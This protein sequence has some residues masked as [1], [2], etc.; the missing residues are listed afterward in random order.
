MKASVFTSDLFMINV[1]FLMLSVFF[2]F[3]ALSRK[4]IGI[5]SMLGVYIVL[6]VGMVIAFLTMAVEIYWKRKAKQ[7]LISNIQ[8]FV[9]KCSL[10]ITCK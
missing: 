10:F 3:I 8:R 5:M 9:S 7:A 4:R 2:S 6:C 1:A